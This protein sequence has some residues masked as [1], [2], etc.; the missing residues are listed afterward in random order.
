[1]FVG[2]AKSLS[3]AA[4]EKRKITLSFVITVATLSVF[5]VPGT[6]CASLLSS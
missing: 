2:L 3:R 4:N 5:Q 6:L 1:M